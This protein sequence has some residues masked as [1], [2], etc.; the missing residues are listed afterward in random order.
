MKLH[1]QIMN[2]LIGQDEIEISYFKGN[3]RYRRNL[4]APV[5]CYGVITHKNNRHSVDDGG[6]FSSAYLQCYFGQ[7]VMIGCL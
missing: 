4:S 1:R 6:V 2:K 5:V 3:A 7:E